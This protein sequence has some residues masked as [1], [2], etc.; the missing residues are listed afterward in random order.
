M[1]TLS[2]AT[3]L[4][5]FCVGCES[6]QVH[7]A[8]LVL[9][10]IEVGNKSTLAGFACSTSDGRLLPGRSRALLSRAFQIS[11]SDQ[12]VVVLR[13]TVVM[14]YVALGG[15]PR[16]RVTALANFCGAEGHM[17]APEPSRRVCLDLEPLEIPVKTSSAVFDL[18]ARAGVVFEDYVKGR[19]AGQLVTGDAPDQEAIVRMVGTTETCDELAARGG[20]DFDSERLLG[21][22]YSCPLVP[23]AARGEIVLDFEGL[24]PCERDVIGC[25][26]TAF[27]PRDQ[28]DLLGVDRAGSAE[29]MPAQ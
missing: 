3:L 21:C 7:T 23:S 16:C 5:G 29:S 9:S 28:R 4:L 8:E 2:F 18:V 13:A 17:C 24:G 1:K 10:A 25:A 14:D 12:S 15:Y 26:G 27:S 22:T 19:V 11:A 6:E 20:L